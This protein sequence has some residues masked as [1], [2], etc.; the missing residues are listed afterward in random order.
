MLQ[1]AIVGGLSYLIINAIEKKR[2]GLL[3]LFNI[4]S[5]VAI[6]ALTSL[7]LG[8]MAVMFGFPMVWLAPLILLYFLFPALYCRYQ[9]NYPWNVSALYGGVVF[10]LNLIV[11]VILG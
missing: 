9:M 4:I 6:P 10:G 3:V 2:D 8:F 7:L 5:F 1:I 11:S